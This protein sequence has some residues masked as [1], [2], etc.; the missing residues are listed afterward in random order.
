MVDLIDTVQLQEVD[1]AIVDLFDITLPDGV[2]TVYLFN[3]LDAGS[4]NIY[5]PNKSNTTMNEYVAMP[6]E[7]DGISMQSSGAQNRPTLRMANIPVL[8]RTPFANNSDG[9]EDEIVF[10]TILEDNNIFSNDDFLDTKIL[11]RRTLLSK[12]FSVGDSLPGGGPVEF[13]SAKYVVDRVSAENNLVV[14]FEL[15]SP[16]DIEGVS[17]PNRV[18]VGRY[19]PWRYQGDALS[20]EGGCTWPLDSNGRFFDKKDQVITKNISSIAL[21][22][23]SLTYTL[24]ANDTPPTRVRTE[25]NSHTQIWRAIRDVPINKPPATSPLYWYRED[26]CGKLIT[27]CKLRY[28]G[29]NSDTDL[30]TSKALQFGGYPGAKTFK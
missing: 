6:I 11:Y 5:F 8:T 2:T 26:V 30:D 19:C 13:P 25:D 9:V 3:G 7:I 10:N 24:N 29:N 4:D 14:E 28:Q 27:S 23:N 18:V 21:W 22:S 1:D 15:A 16:M 20:S 12:T 17:L